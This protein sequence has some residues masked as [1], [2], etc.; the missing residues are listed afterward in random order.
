MNTSAAAR[1]V[2]VV[3]VLSGAMACGAETPTQPPAPVYELK[4]GTFTGNVKVGG[5]VGFPFTVVNPG[6]IQ[7]AITALTPSGLTMGL[8]LGFWEPATEV[9]TQQVSTPSATLNVVFGATPS[10]P[11]EYCVAIFD[12]GNVVVSSDFTLT[13]TYY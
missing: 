2:A 9:C 11:G 6:E 8:G 3:L 1:I 10:S 5:T 7:L 4:T 12:T 13:V